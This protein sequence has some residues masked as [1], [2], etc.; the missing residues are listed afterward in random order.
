MELAHAPDLVDAENPGRN[1]TFSNH[2][3]LASQSDTL[4]IGASSTAVT[5]GDVT[6]HRVPVDRSEPR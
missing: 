1:P 2:E 5:E 6:L 3:A 4:R